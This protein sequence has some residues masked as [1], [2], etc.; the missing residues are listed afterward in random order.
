M[1][2]GA[3][4]VG[5]WFSL[6]FCCRASSSAASLRKL[7]E[8]FVRESR[9]LRFVDD[10]VLFGLVSSFDLE[11]LSPSLPVKDFKEIELRVFLCNDLC[12]SPLVLGR[13]PSLDFFGGFRVWLCWFC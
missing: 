11:A 5:F 10:F 13:F 1:S 7:F 6:S 2:V 12:P 8:D 3:G 9:L 4:E